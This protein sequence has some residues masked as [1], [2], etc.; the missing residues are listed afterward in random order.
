MADAFAVNAL[1]I[2]GTIVRGLLAAVICFLLAY[3]TE[4][5][6]SDASSWSLLKRYYVW[7]L[8]SSIPI[9]IA[10][11]LNDF[12]CHGHGES[13]FAMCRVS[14]ALHGVWASPFV[15]S[16]AFSTLFVYSRLS[17]FLNGSKEAR[18]WNVFRM[19][20]IA[21]CFTLSVNFVIRAAIGAKQTFN[22]I[23]ENYHGSV[24]DVF[25]IIGSICYLALGVQIL[26]MTL[27]CYY[28]IIWIILSSSS[29]LARLKRTADKQKV[30]AF[31]RRMYGYL[32]VI[33]FSVLCLFPDILVLKST[34]ASSIIVF[35]FVM[36]L[37][38]LEI[39]RFGIAT[40][41]SNEEEI[42]TEL[43]TVPFP[44]S[45]ECPEDEVMKEELDS[46]GKSIGGG[47]FG[48]FRVL[49]FSRD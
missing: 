9:L 19:I 31:E 43:S 27:Y 16:F 1:S 8:F 35:V 24:Q 47:L 23:V 30:Q 20:T 46:G 34:F 4:R 36:C 5:N 48:V 11:G 10:S 7:C 6:L 33:S 37:H 49:G 40:I 38:L 12:G 17:G 26:G 41:D 2:S 15:I 28:N 39:I 14:M 45:G 29:K 32:A 42:V 3:K 22:G 18:A 44:V 21:L 13:A 25:W